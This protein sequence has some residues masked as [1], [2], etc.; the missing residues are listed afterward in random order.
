MG[1]EIYRF[2]IIIPGGPAAEDSV[3]ALSWGIANSLMEARYP[4][5]QVIYLGRG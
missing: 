5:C 4:N 2:R 3:E 1:K